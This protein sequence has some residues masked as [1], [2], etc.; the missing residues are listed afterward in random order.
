MI[1]QQV[2]S[3]TKPTGPEFNQFHTD[4]DYRRSVEDAKAAQ[5]EARRKAVAEVPELAPHLADE[6]LPTYRV[7][8]MPIQPRR[9]SLTKQMN[10]DEAVDLAVESFGVQTVLRSLRLVLAANG[11]DVAGKT[12]DDLA[13]GGERP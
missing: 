6:P 4:D 7:L 11:I 2:E 9:V 5:L 3:M 1:L 8:E 13:Q 12:L 10:C